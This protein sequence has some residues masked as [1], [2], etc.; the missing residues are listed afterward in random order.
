MTVSPCCSPPASARPRR[1][2]LEEVTAYDSHILKDS[3]AK[4][5]ERHQV[6]VDAQSIAQEGQ[7][8]RQQEVRVEAREED[9]GVEMALEL[10][11]VGAKE[12]VE[13]GQDADGGIAGPFDRE[14]ESQGQPEQHPGDEAEERKKQWLRPHHARF[15]T[16]ITADSRRCGRRCARRRSLGGAAGCPADS[17]SRARA[18]HRTPPV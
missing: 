3:P 5:E 15:A 1:A 12:R 17:A 8:R 14:V 6:E 2:L 4:S 16:N 9:A 10:R 7:A 11:P 13:R 18:C